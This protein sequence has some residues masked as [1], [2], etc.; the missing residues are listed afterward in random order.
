MGRHEDGRERVGLE[1]EAITKVSLLHGVASLLAIP[2]RWVSSSIA[3]LLSRPRST[4]FPRSI[5]PNL[6]AVAPSGSL[7]CMLIVRGRVVSDLCSE[8]SKHSAQ[9][10]LPMRSTLALFAIF[11]LHPS[12][13]KHFACQTRPPFSTKSP[14]L[15]SLYTGF[16]H[17]TQSALTPPFAMK[18][19]RQRKRGEDVGELGSGYMVESRW[20]VVVHDAHA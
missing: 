8:V 9:H 6:P 14:S 12:H 5:P 11:L 15:L 19:S 4:L 3:G 2:R 20:K 16:L 13:S 10:G 7:R 1:L 18:Q 17:S